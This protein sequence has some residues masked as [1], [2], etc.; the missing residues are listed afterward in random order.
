M[1]FC[2][3]SGQKSFGVG[4]SCSDAGPGKGDAKA[5][6]S[7]ADARTL[8]DGV[9]RLVQEAMGAVAAVPRLT[10]AAQS[11]RRGRQGASVI[12]FSLR[13]ARWVFRGGM[14]DHAALADRRRRD[15]RCRYRV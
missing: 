2:S 4:V 11:I 9:P 10:A 13:Y 14:D 7:G 6:S 8:D 12:T 5:L 3:T 15:L 1:L